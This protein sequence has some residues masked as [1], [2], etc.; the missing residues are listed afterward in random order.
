MSV[1]LVFISVRTTVTVL[2]QL[3]A[4]TVNATMV[5]REMETT[6][7]SNYEDNKMSFSDIHVYIFTNTHTAWEKCICTFMCTMFIFPN[8]YDELLIHVYKSSM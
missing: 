6:A 7:V 5:M 8:V 1:Q 2:I 4:T 3:V